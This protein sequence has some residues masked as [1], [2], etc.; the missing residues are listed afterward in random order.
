MA[1][2]RCPCPD[3]V[4]IPSCWTFEVHLSPDIPHPPPPASTSLT[5]SFPSGPC[6][7]GNIQSYIAS[8]QPVSAGGGGGGWGGWFKPWTPGQG[9][10]T[11]LHGS[12]ATALRPQVVFHCRE[13]LRLG[14]RPFEMGREPGEGSICT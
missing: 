4:P 11:F 1:I 12:G 2:H 10:L 13:K 7:A 9:T 8:K 14:S 6:A 3:A 5:H